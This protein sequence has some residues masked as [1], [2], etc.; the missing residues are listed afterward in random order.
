[1]RSQSESCIQDTSDKVNQ[2]ECFSKYVSTV[3]ISIFSRIYQF[4]FGTIK[5]FILLSK[6]ILL[7]NFEWISMLFYSLKV[8]DNCVSSLFL[9]WK[10]Q[11]FFQEQPDLVLFWLLINT[12][13]T[14][15]SLAHTRA[16][17]GPQAGQKERAVSR[18]L[19]RIQYYNFLN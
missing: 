2:S 8:F 16:L 9:L 12:S 17:A 10:L 6:C 11:F 15:V 5:H 13:R 18:Y 1:M 7:K 3:S 4:G 14:T 19:F